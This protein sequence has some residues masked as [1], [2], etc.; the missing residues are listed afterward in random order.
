MNIPDILTFKSGEK[1]Q[2]HTFFERRKEMRDML[3]HYIYGNFDYMQKNPTSFEF[4]KMHKL[5]NS[6]VEKTVLANVDGFK[7][8]FYIYESSLD[9]GVKKPVIIYLRLR[10]QYLSKTFLPYDD[11]D[12]TQQKTSILPVQYLV[13]KGYTVA[14][15]D[16]EYI[17]VDDHDAKQTGVYKAF[18]GENSDCGQI[19]TWAWGLSRT[20]D[21]FFGHPDLYDSRKIGVSG[22]SR[23]GKT[24][25]LA[26]A[27]DERLS[28][29]FSN[30]SG[31][32][33]AALHR[34]KTG[35]SIEAINKAFPLV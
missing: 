29:A 35:E 23:G 8:I 1:V 5:Q 34:G 2:K 28:F 21:Y 26:A 9:E 16:T 32:T 17:S 24:A 31:C 10:S 7:F 12:Y 30:D 20:A 18:L 25:L 22:H 33:G 27:S 19:R 11:E 15:L 14:A 13:K 3:Y 6:V 4:L